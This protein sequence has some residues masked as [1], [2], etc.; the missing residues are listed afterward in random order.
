MQRNR[1][2]NTNHH[3]QV[4]R[5]YL[6]IHKQIKIIARASF[7]LTSQTFIQTKNHKPDLSISSQMTR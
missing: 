4:E 2:S 7:V 3:N 5:P 6:M 1:V